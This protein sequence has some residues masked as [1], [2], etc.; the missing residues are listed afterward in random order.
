MDSQIIESVTEWE[1]VSVEDGYAGFRDLVDREFSGA[2]AAGGTWAFALNGRI[3]GVFDG[4]IEN[5]EDAE[6][7]AHA[8]PDSAL[9]LLY[10]MKAR[11]GETRAK[12]YTNDTPL[13]EADETLSSG[14]FTGYVELSENVLSGD[15][16]VVY[17]G[18]KSMSAA[19]VGNSRQLV[20]GE[21]A[22]ERADDEVGI[23]AVRDVD[24][25]LAELPEPEPGTE[26]GSD[27]DPGADDDA[28][29]GAAESADA[30]A[31][32][33]AQ[34][35][36][37]R[38]EDDR[39]TVD[40]AQAA[41]DVESGAGDAQAATADAEARAAED[42]REPAEESDADGDRSGIAG[43]ARA[44]AAG[45]ADAD[46]GSEAA[47]EDDGADGATEAGDGE[48][49]EDVSAIDEDR[50]ED[51][52]V[53]V[54][55]PDEAAE[56]AAADVDAADVDA[57]DETGGA[58]GTDG[59][60][61]DDADPLEGSDAG[62][63]AVAPHVDPPESG[64]QGEGEPGE[65]GADV[66]S[67]EAQWRE[68]K[69]IPAL[70]PGDTADASAAAAAQSKSKAV[71]KPKRRNATTRPAS[72]PGAGERNAASGSGSRSRDVAKKLRALKEKLQTLA[73]ERERLEAERDELREERDEL[74]A[75]H[76]ELQ[77]ERDE[78]REER[79]ELA[80]RAERLES[81]VSELEDEIEQLR[82][83]GSGAVAT[84][85]TMGSSE[86]L[87]GTNLFVRYGDKGDP[88]LEGAHAGRASRDEVN[89]N[90]RLEHHT[91]FETEGLAVDNRPFD[92][93]LRETVEFNFVRW[94]VRDLLYEI[95][96]T[97]NQ[98][99]LR[100][101]YDAIPKIDRVE[102]RGTVP[103]ETDGD[104]AEEREFDVVLW[105]GMGNPLL[106][107][108]LNT[109]RNAAGEGMVATVASGAKQVA[110]S[111]DSLGAGFVVTSSYFS[112][113]ALDI[114]AEETGSSLLSRSKRKAFVKLSRKRGFHL[115][116]VETRNDEFYVN[117]PD[118]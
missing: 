96:N 6:L 79:D 112:P 104:D 11:G 92:E 39:G 18:G 115:C 91:S 59:I 83:E 73:D 50:D 21:E 109:G 44:S 49:A 113:G 62:A 28:G 3:V 15:Y 64:A 61:R 36:R 95:Q 30:S 56:D 34:A 13:S 117:F 14:G 23:Y 77:S 82:S 107:A 45:A 84:D 38:S 66:F 1:S 110:E 55:F 48:S 41:A 7:R 85:R 35:D 42:A 4:D 89:A 57:V 114:A 9:P 99:Q 20:T 2:V 111:D 93:F 106:V 27:P 76:E 43:G 26:S 118:L 105:D 86:A 72:P 19:F 103:T 58:A 87:S 32:D 52:V 80:E 51:D 60:P 5:F 90:L 65:S 71:A 97:G 37:S 10:A 81:K 116:L 78:F 75:E 46:D 98:Q 29:T 12:Y 53:I 33:G 17:Y 22:F 100:G 24:L 69:S 102:L 88:T 108:D 63:D 40:D 31:G 70:D 25:E 16:Y 8:A 74:R 101:L 47:R 54:D 94:I 67:K 68:T